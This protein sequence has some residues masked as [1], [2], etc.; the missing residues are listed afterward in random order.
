MGGGA[1]KAPV[2][3]AQ[4]N[5]DRTASLLDGKDE[6]YAEPPEKPQPFNP[7]A[8]APAATAP[9]VQPAYMTPPP[10]RPIPES[11]QKRDGD[12]I[13]ALK[14]QAQ[15]AYNPNASMPPPPQVPGKGR[16]FCAQCGTEHMTGDRA[17][18]CFNCGHPTNLLTPQT[19]VGV[20]PPPSVP[21][22][23]YEQAGAPMPQI[24]PP[25][26]VPA[27][28]S[29]SG[30]AQAPRQQPGTFVVSLPAEVNTLRSH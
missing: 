9:T 30:G 14:A 11:P 15:Y 4:T 13:D 19:S 23:D 26:H 25:A 20:P 21:P 6:H 16:E 3:P 1:S 2:P 7:A 22:A 12:D 24:T 27:P 17:N 10:A 28:L 8:G 5:D 29:N 18:F